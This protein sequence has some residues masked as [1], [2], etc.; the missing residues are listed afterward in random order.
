MVTN[1]IYNLGNIQENSGFSVIF[2]TDNENVI[3]GDGTL[4]SVKG[5]SSGY[6]AMV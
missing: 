4:D 1:E 3:M 2:V 5:V 6:L